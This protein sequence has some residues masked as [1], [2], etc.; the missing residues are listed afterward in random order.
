MNRGCVAGCDPHQATTTNHYSPL[1]TQIR[2]TAMTKRTLL[3]S[4]GGSRT[5]VLHVP[6]LSPACLPVSSVTTYLEGC[7]MLLGP[8]CGGSTSEPSAGRCAG[9]AV[10]SGLPGA[11]GQVVVLRQQWGAVPLMAT[12]DLEALGRTRADLLF[13]KRLRCPSWGF[14]DTGK[15]KKE[16]TIV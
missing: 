2:E 15:N 10:P 16:A 12:F 11:L 9:I 7:P 5:P 8:V 6:L 4:H 3:H 14:L 1:H 13:L